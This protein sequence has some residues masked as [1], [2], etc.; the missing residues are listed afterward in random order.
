MIMFK[1]AVRK[2]VHILIGIAGASGSGKT[3]TALEVAAGL[4]GENGRIAGIDTE[5]GRMLH[6]ADRFKFDHCDLMAPFSPDYYLEA[7]R[8]AEAQNYDVIVVDSF[9]HEHAGIG[10]LL[11]MA[12]AELVANPR[13]KSP[14]NWATPKAKHKKLMD[15][16]LQVRAHI[17]LAVRAEEK[18]RIERILDE[19]SGREK[20]VVV[21]AGWQ[22]IT[23]KTVMFE[24]VVS[25][26]MS[27]EHP[28]VPIE[29]SGK[30]QDQHRFAFPPGQRVNREAG[31]L[32]AEWAA[33]GEPVVIPP[34]PLPELED[35]GR[36]EAAKGNDALD[37]WIKGLRREDKTAVMP[38]GATLREIA[39][40]AD[41]A[42]VGMTAA[43]K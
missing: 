42:K 20:T 34:P 23:E 40:T 36:Y 37:A 11:E 14:A 31:R 9:S 33:G 13:M 16:L 41:A 8:A 19:R 18:I 5:A 21:P 7:I 1:P 12:D 2:N 43:A 24:M 27:P 10:G 35:A 6:Y 22:P 4:A 30:I 39:H 28:G 29:G 15:A 32:L 17:V 38:I 26:V 25:F 3:F